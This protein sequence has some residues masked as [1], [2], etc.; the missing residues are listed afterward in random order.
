M[1][2]DFDKNKNEANL[3]KHG[4][5]FSNVP[6]L[7]WDSAYLK[8]DDRK[9]YGETRIQGFVRDKNAKPYV[10]IFTMRNKKVRVISFRRAHEK[11]RN[12]FK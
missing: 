5:D 7:D 3:I 4:L 10:V 1:E 12:L 6:D 11:E 8:I 9:E 2:F